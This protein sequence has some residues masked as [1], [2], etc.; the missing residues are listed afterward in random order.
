MVLFC[1][2]RVYNNIM[3]MKEDIFKYYVYSSLKTPVGFK[4][5]DC[6]D[7]PIH[8]EYKNPDGDPEIAC[9]FENCPIKEHKHEAK[10]QCIG[11]PV[12]PPEEGNIN[13]E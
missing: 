11:T 6:W 2:K 1:L 4:P 5:G 10:R 12:Y 7:C 8:Y 13:Y 9:V 3:I